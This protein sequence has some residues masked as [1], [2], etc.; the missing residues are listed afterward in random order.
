MFHA[1]SDLAKGIAEMA[2]T[3]DVKIRAFQ[4]ELYMLS[5]QD[6]DYRFYSLYDK[7]Y[8]HDILLEAYRQCRA[9]DGVAGVD[10]VEFADIERKGLDLWVAQLSQML[11]SRSYVPQPVMRVYIEKPDGGQRPL[12]I[13]TIRDRVVQ[14]ACKIVIE[15][16][17]EA[18]LND[19]SYGY[20][21]KR[22]AADAVRQI[23]RSI[24]QGY[25]HVY[26]ADLKG[27]F[28]SIPQN[29]LMDKMAR[30]ISDKSM[31]ALIRKFLRAPV[32]ETNGDGKTTIT[33]VTKGT[34]QGG[35]ASPLFANIYLNDFSEL[36]NT[37][38]PCRMISYADDFVILFKKPFTEVQLAWIKNK[39]EMEG[40]M[41]NEAKT[42]LVNMSRQGSEF[43]FLGFN[44]K[45]VP[46]IW[47]KEHSYVKIQPSKKSQKKFK[48]AIREIVKHRTSKRLPQLI[49]EVNPIIRGWKNYFSQSGYPQ[50]VF[51]V[52]D[53]FV[54]GRFYRWAKRLSQ[55]SSKC[56]I[57]GTWKILWKKGLE[58]FVTPS[59]GTVKGT[60]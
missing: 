25:S 7:V 41:L 14:T 18:H 6:A 30:R 54:I 55:R 52:M 1:F 17:F 5:K 39:L 58:F 2:T 57:P 29:R 21:P 9:N 59:A 50:K 47:R 11:S 42:R 8:R 35:V 36:I 12:G 4:R 32:A 19:G 56:L 3:Q 49:A 38:T 26:D 24:K 16:I 40:L 27:Y 44:F 23:D 46:C 53:W 37:K 34:P 51:F 15:P 45:K 13:P 10:G 33:K 22:G 48:D 20:R 60:L 43:D 31:L 28:D